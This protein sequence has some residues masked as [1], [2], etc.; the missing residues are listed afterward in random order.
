MNLQYINPLSLLS[1]NQTHTVKFAKVTSGADQSIVAAVTGKKIRVLSC[2]LINGHATVVSATAW[3]SPAG[4]TLSGS[5]VLPA[6][7]AT[8]GANT[9]VLPFN[10]NGWFEGATS[11]ALVLDTTAGTVT[12]HISYI[13]V[14]G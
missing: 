2:V 13:E 1:E 6:A 4:T 12:G 8:W 7:A 10:P 11:G 9:L 14:D 5:I 3:E